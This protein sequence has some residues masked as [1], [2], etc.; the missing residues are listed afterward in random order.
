MEENERE[1]GGVVMKEVPET[2]RHVEILLRDFLK[3]TSD[4]WLDHQLRMALYWL[5]Q[6]EDEQP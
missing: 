4:P 2:Y 1:G 5:S 3:T 6:C